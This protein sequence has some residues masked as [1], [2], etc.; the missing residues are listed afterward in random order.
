MPRRPS[1]PL[2]APLPRRTSSPPL[3][4]SHSQYGTHPVAVAA[5][6][7][8]TSHMHSLVASQPHC[9][10]A[11]HP[12]HGHIAHSR[13]RGAWGALTVH[14]AAQRPAYDR[15]AARL[16]YCPSSPQLST[17]PPTLHLHS[18]LCLP[19]PLRHPSPPPPHPAAAAAAPAAPYWCSR[20]QRG[21]NLPCCASACT[22]QCQ[23]SLPLM[24][25][26]PRPS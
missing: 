2:T 15:G 22:P 3:R 4:S 13:S 20:S 1:P 23:T 12:S 7:P 21:A 24:C 25:R 17:P 16:V 19:S 6:G 14:Q 9:A 11:V 5:S 26:C 10:N 8:S 18:L